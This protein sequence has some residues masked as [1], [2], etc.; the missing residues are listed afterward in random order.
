MLEA[1]KVAVYKRLPRPLQ[2]QAVRWGTPNFTVGAI[3]LITDGQGRLLL[4]RPTYRRGWLPTGGF[5]GRGE[6]ATEALRREVE[7]EL[8]LQM[9]F[10]EPHRVYL[11]VRR[12]GVTF[13]SVGVLPAGQE[14][15]LRG[16]EL[17]D[18]RWFGLDEIPSLPNDY[19]EGLPEEDLEA[20]RRAGRPA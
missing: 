15:R 17:S 18:L 4:V 8:G 5:L 13:I 19:H 2:L 11:D 9:G 20:I 3:G 16:P 1:L 12:Q 14:P 6:T 10:E 7:E